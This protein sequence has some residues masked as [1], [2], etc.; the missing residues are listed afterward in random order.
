MMKQ[1]SFH[2]NH[3]MFIL[4]IHSNVKV[5]YKIIKNNI[6]E[7]T[8]AFEEHKES[9]INDRSLKHRGVNDLIPV[10]NL[11]NSIPF[12]HETSS[13]KSSING[14]SNTEVININTSHAVIDNNSSSSKLK[15]TWRVNFNKFFFT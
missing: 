6:L 13:N 2:T 10:I 9:Y 4:L 14:N 8:N 7:D 3:L 12:N 11:T 1:L 5:D 15:T